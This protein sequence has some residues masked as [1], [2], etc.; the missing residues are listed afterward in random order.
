MKFRK[1]DEPNYSEFWISTLQLFGIGVLLGANGR[2]VIHILYRW[3]L[4]ECRWW[5]IAQYQTFSAS[6]ACQRID[7]ICKALET[8]PDGPLSD[9]Y[10]H[11]TRVADKLPKRKARYLEDEENIN[12]ISK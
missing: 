3:P 12:Q 2:I 1:Q 10:G 4:P 11:W 5:M 6:L 7:E 8:I 9:E